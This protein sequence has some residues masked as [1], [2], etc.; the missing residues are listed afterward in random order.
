MLKYMCH[1]KVAILAEVKARGARFAGKVA[2]TFSAAFKL[3]S[4][5]EVR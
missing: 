2:R 1:W 5:E 4:S 3:I